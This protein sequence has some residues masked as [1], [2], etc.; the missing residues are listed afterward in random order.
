MNVSLFLTIKTTEIGVIFQLNL[1][2]DKNR[3]K[4]RKESVEIE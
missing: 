2:M 3:M 4:Y 1:A